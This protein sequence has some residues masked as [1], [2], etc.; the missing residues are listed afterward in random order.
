[1]FDF[2]VSFCIR[3]R[4]CSIIKGKALNILDGGKTSFLKTQDGV[5]RQTQF[6]CLKLYSLDRAEPAA[7]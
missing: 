6:D 7:D 3:C 5:C 1:M 2:E 4:V